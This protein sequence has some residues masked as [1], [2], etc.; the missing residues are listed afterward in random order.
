MNLSVD[1]QEYGRTNNRAWRISAASWVDG[2]PFRVHGKGHHSTLQRRFSPALIDEH[3]AAGFPSVRWWCTKATA[4]FEPRHNPPEL[5]STY[6]ILQRG[7]TLTRTRHVFTDCGRDQTRVTKQ[8]RGP[9]CAGQ[10][11][12]GNRS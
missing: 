2:I 10:Q 1:V 9:A 7:A 11:V 3:G 12:H 4:R 8:S 6:F 5:P